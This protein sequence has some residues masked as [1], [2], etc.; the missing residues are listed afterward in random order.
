MPTAEQILE[1]F[2]LP[3][4]TPDW[5][6]DS[7][8]CC[9]DAFARGWQAGQDR[10]LA[11]LVGNAALSAA[12]ELVE[13]EGRDGSEA[14]TREWLHSIGFVD[15]ENQLGPRYDPACRIKTSSGPLV[16]WNF[17]GECWL[18]EPMD[19][20][21]LRTRRDVLNLCKAL[22]VNIDAAKRTGE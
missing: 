4:E 17:N 13:R 1:A 9:R 11:F 18:I 16:L 21:P 15:R 7:E 14:I 6:D 12:A 2:S 20:F 19:N 10:G 3:V 5:L 22:G 8:D